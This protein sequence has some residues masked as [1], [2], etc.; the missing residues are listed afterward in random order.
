M[1]RP[2]GATVAQVAEAIHWA[3]HT[4]HGS[5][6]GLKK[7]HGISVEVF[8]RVRQVGPN[9]AGTKG[10]YTVYRLNDEARA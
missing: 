4:V 5:F 1:R 6:A 7:R 3:P 9:K 8:E 2:E 10:S